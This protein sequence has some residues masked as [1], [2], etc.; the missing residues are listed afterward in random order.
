MVHLNAITKRYPVSGGMHTVLDKV[1]FSLE[2]GQRFGVIGRNGSGKS[3]LIRLLSGAELPT[4]GSIIR[5]MSVSWP[6][7]FTGA[8]QGSLTG[9]DNLRFI[10]RVYG[11]KGEEIRAFVEDFAE[12]G[13]YFREPVKTY[14]S[15][16][17]ARLAFGLSLAIEFDCFLIDEV[18]AVGDERFQK[19]CHEELFEKRRDR[20]FVIVSHDPALISR[21]CDKA[22]VLRSG[23]LEMFSDVQQALD[24]Y[25]DVTRLSERG[26]AS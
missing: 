16:M 5:Q 3:T 23:R 8:F 4:T 20:A 24:F 2:R 18:I 7:A 12:L 14:S 9:L 21:Y 19:K 15:G 6:L 25:R 26:L 1:S 13:K 11:I 17:Q 22:A 10:A